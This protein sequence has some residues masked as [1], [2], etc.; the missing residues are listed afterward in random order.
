MKMETLDKATEAG[1]YDWVRR[2]VS[3]C[4]ERS[5]LMPVEKATHGGNGIT[6]V[7]ISREELSLLKAG[8]EEILKQLKEVR[9]GDSGGV[10]VKNITAIEFMSAVK[11]CRST[12]DQLVLNNKIKTIKRRRKI[13]VPVTEI[14]RY[15]NDPSIG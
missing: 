14:D 10:Q 7:M 5:G 6:L 11:I 1:I 3:E 12:F 4:L 8:Q 2:A 15:F 9:K 13:Y